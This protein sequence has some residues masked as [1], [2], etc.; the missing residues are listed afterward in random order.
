MDFLGSRITFISES[1]KYVKD[2]MTT[3]CQDFMILD[4]G[5]KPFLF[6]LEAR[7]RTNL[8]ESQRTH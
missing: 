3:V 2:S 8:F 5:K 7:S 6:E 4:A 1:N